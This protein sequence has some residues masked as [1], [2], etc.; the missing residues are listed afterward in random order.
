GQQ[1]VTC[2]QY[3]LDGKRFANGNAIGTVLVRDAE[4][5]NILNLLRGLTGR[6]NAV[7]FDP[8]SRYVSGSDSFGNTIVWDLASSKELFNAS[9]LPELAELKNASFAFFDNSG[10]KLFFGGNS[11]KLY[12]VNFIQ[13]PNSVKIV[14]QFKHPIQTAAAS[15]KGEH[16]ALATDTSIAVFNTNTEQLIKNIQGCSRHIHDIKFPPGDTL[17]STTCSAES[18]SFHIWSVKTGQ[19]TRKLFNLQPGHRADKIE[20]SRDGKYA[21]VLSHSAQTVLYDIAR[22]TIIQILTGHREEVLNANFSPDSKAILSAGADDQI[23]MYKW[24]QIFENDNLPDAS[25]TRYVPEIDTL[26][27]LYDARGVPT[28]IGKR[29]LT[30]SQKATVEGN[31]VTIMVWDS[32]YEDNDTISLYFNGKWV[33][34]KYALRTDK[35]VLHLEMSADKENKL[36]MY[37]HNLG[38]RPPNTAAISVF[39]G[40]KERLIN[41]SSNMQLSDSIQFVRSHSGNKNANLP[42]IEDGR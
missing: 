24:K 10:K 30:G 16:I 41:L 22:D 40:K 7:A 23:K 33:L 42:P 8:N 27:L 12:V 6:V 35:K 34:K 17:I 2:V 13:N 25:T 5:G 15:S 1:D 4:K 20:Y 38:K 21:L 9:K 26:K 36:I 14:Q 39:D 11:K 18:N 19:K 32:E 28:K 37:A 31:K 3:T 29:I